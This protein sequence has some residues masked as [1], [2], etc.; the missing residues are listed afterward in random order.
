MD[1]RAPRRADERG[2][3]LEPARARAA[4]T[5]SDS[6]GAGRRQRRGP[7]VFAVPQDRP[8]G[9]PRAVATAGR[10]ARDPP[11]RASVDF[12]AQVSPWDESRFPA[13]R[14][15]PGTPVMAKFSIIY[16]MRVY[17]GRFDI[18]LQHPAFGNGRYFWGIENDAQ[19][20]VKPSGAR[21]RSPKTVAGAMQV[22]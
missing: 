15:R 2:R 13:G 9:R 3:I 18:Q 7:G 8:Y 5:R 12:I 21:R 11:P 16:L 17:C 20:E 4:V 1:G 6:G 14:R 22:I 19:I 10:D